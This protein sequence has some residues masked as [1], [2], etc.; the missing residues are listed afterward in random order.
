MKRQNSQLSSTSRRDPPPESL[1]AK[2]IGCMS[3]IIHL[4]SK[5]QNRHKKSLTFGKSK[6][7][8]DIIVFSSS[9]TSD[10]CLASAAGISPPTPKP[11]G[12]RRSR[13][14]K[15]GKRTEVVDFSR[16]RIS[17]DLPTRSPTL[18][19]EIR[20]SSTVNSPS[21]IQKSPALV[22][23]LMGLE[24]V[25]A[26]PVEEPSNEK[27][28]KLLGALEK[29]DNDLKA[30]KDIIMAFRSP[31]SDQAATAVAGNCLNRD[32]VKTISERKCRDC[33]CSDIEK[34]QQQHPSAASVFNESSRSHLNRINRTGRGRENVGNAGRQETQKQA[35]KKNPPAIEDEDTISISSLN[36]ISKLQERIIKLQQISSTTHLTTMKK[37]KKEKE[38]PALTWRSKAM[39]ESLDEISN[40]I[41]WGFKHEMAKIGMALQHHIYRELIDEMLTDMITKSSACF[42]PF[43]S[44]S[45]PPFEACRRRLRF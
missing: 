19:A 27:R 1:R 11:Q 22:A 37:E 25:P 12:H 26:T 28:R 24:A 17:C 30:L 9:S 39:A 6:Q 32:K 20:R 35:K 23:R 8:K 14:N 29:C 5:Y 2:S 16:R 43:H 44:S 31:E 18:S 7:E 10:Q 3:G 13:S 38:D 33:N 45:L 40:Q 36:P 21:K 4:L 34:Q 41:S 42:L 15:E